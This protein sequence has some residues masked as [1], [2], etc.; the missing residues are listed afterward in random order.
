[1]M[2]RLLVAATAAFAVAFAATSTAS[3]AGD[4]IV[5]FDLTDVDANLHTGW[6]LNVSV[7]GGPH[8]RVQVDTGSAG[9]AI[10]ASAIP[11]DAKRI[12]PGEIRYSSS[13]KILRGT[14]YNVSI[15]F[16][17]VP[18]ART[19]AIPVLG[20]DR[21]TCDTERHPTCTVH[22]NEERH[23]GV[24]GVGFG[25]H[26]SGADLSDLTG[27]RDD[28]VNPFLQLESM[29]SGTMRRAYTIEP[30][31]ITLGLRS[32]TESARWTPFP[33][34]TDASGDWKPLQ[35]CFTADAYAPSCDDTRVLVDTGVGSVIFSTPDR[36]S[37]PVA[38]GT[39]ASIRISG[40]TP[41][42]FTFTSTGDDCSARGLSCARWSHRSGRS[43]AINT[44]R[45]LLDTVDYRFD[46]EAGVVSF[47]AET[48]G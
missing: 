22:P 43:Y 14:L 8:H 3:P 2:T 4:A 41:L 24:L 39:H 34:A 29:V 23:I 38:A 20:V 33:L 28:T 42:T 48:D 36:P 1:M 40:R 16:T 12:G 31:G 5:R 46:D 10:A 11:A 26:H 17:D 30:A 47:R 37:E 13:G 19:I 44:S 27:G 35:G 21:V 15:A 18:D 25:R 9:L 6:F 45:H 7:G 32:Q